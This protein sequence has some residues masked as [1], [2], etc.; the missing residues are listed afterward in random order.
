ME[1]TIVT[2]TATSSATGNIDLPGIVRPAAATR[3]IAG[4]HI[5]R[6][7][8]NRRYRLGIMHSRG[9][10][11]AAVVSVLAALAAWLV[12]SP[13]SSAVPPPASLPQTS[14]SALDPAVN[15]GSGTLTLAGRV[16]PLRIG[17]ATRADIEAFAGTPDSEGY[18]E[19]LIELGYDCT[20]SYGTPDCQTNFFLDAANRLVQF[21]SASPNY[22]AFGTVTVGTP[23]Q[24]AARL[25]HAQALAGCLTG[26]WRHGSR[27]DIWL[28]IE[29]DGASVRLMGG[30]LHAVGGRVSWLFLSQ[31]G[32]PPC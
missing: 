1:A 25:A 9:P 16:G 29:I 13:A 28:M 7:E 14:P 30:K 27:S 20:V 31:R 19:G 21:S 5:S 8:C 2:A 6:R 22:N 32:L 11:I 3:S 15:G 26:I 18:N 23:T 17:I 12:L 4:K 24:R 10:S